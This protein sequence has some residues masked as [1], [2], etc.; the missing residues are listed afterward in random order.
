MR[1]LHLL[2]ALLLTIA[3]ADVKATGDNTKVPLIDLGPWQA[4]RSS[5]SS[6]TKDNLTAQ[7]KAVVDAIH[8]ACQNVGFFMIEN[9]G[10]DQTVMDNAWDAS[11]QFFSMSTEEKLL[12]KTNN[13]TFSPY[14]YEQSEALA[15]GKQLDSGSDDRIDG[16]DDVLIKD[17]KETF[18]IG[19][20]NTASGMPPRKW[21]HTPN[22]PAQFQSSIEGYFA[23][24]EQ[25]SLVLL[26]IF[27]LALG[28]EASFFADQMSHHMSALRLAHYYPLAEPKG[29]MH[30]VRAGAHTDYGALTILAA[31]DKGL[32]VF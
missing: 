20:N 8:G 29:E 16:D 5:S 15:K 9:H 4:S 27:A 21:Q 3:A 30:V 17:L 14:G 1:T 7:Q 18:A 23:H 32:E 28:E 6:T 24:M 19:P 26:E 22:V 25:L 12:H 2:V 13:E 10:F 11:Q 31:Q